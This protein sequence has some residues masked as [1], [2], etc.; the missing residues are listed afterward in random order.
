L[1]IIRAERWREWTLSTLFADFTHGTV[2]AGAK[3]QGNDKPK[4]G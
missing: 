1:S 4:N 3:L 2:R